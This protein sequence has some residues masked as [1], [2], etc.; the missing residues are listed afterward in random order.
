VE[1][2]RSYEKDEVT[3][4]VTDVKS[5]ASSVTATGNLKGGF[6]PVVNNWYSEHEVRDSKVIG[7]RFFKAFNVSM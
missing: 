6:F 2:I 4:G 7:G 1:Y 3:T 5:Q